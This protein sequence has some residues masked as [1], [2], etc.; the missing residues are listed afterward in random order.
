MTCTPPPINPDAALDWQK[1]V[2][3]GDCLECENCGEPFCDQCGQHY[4]DCACPGPTQD[5][6]FEYREV[7]GVMEA[8]RL[9]V[10]GN[11]S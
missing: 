7:D 10:D 3:A 11:A 4:A 6:E 2:F 8:R 5:D 9:P 1:V